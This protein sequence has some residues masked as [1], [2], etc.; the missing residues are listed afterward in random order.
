MPC[1]RRGT[2]SIDVTE[3]GVANAI[4]CD[5]DLRTLCGKVGTGWKDG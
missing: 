1:Y 4:M 5:M 3:S 2:G